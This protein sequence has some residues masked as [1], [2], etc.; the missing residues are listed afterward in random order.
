MTSIRK[1]FI[2]VFSFLLVISLPLFSAGDKTMPDKSL[3]KT[4]GHEHRRSGIHDGN[5][6]LT[7]FFNYG[8]FG[9]WF[10]DSN[11][12]QSGIWPKGSGHSYFAEFCPFVGAEVYDGY[13]QR[14]HIFSDG[15]GHTGRAD[16][17]PGGE[18]QYCFEP[19]PGY[20]DPNQDYIAMVNAKGSEDNDG[21]DGIPAHMGSEDDDGKP[22]SW[23][24]VWP[25]KPDW[26]DPRTGVPF[27]NGQYG[28][29]ARASQESYFRMNDDANDEFYFFP[30]PADSSKRG[31]GLEV[32]VRG[33]QWA[34]PQ[35]ED[36]LIFT[37]WITNTGEYLYEKTIFG[38]YGD[39][40]IGEQEDNSDDLS[41]FNKDED[42][43]YQWD[44][45]LYSPA[46]GGFSPGYF[47]WK[48]LESPG[49]PHDGIDNDGDGL[50][51]AD[52]NPWDESQEDG[53]DNDGD[54][55]PKID[56]IGSDGLGPDYPDYPGPDPDGTEG[57][58]VPDRGEPNFEYTDND[59][60]DQ[61]GL[62]SF[63]S[64]DWKVTLIEL[65][66]DEKLW[67]QTIPGSFSKALS[68][69][70]IVMHYGSGY[71][72]V[73]PE[74]NP[75]SRRKFAISMVMGADRDDLV[76][77][78][79]TMQQIYNADYNFAAVPLKP[80]VTA[81]PGDQRVTL[82]WDKISEGSRDPIYGYDFEGYVIYRATDPGFLE[83]YIGTDTYGNKSFNK[84]IAQFDLKNGLK[85]PHPVARDG[86]Q[87]NM[88]SDTGLQYTFIDSGQTW[89]GP[90]ENG[91]TYYYA[92]CSYDKG[93][94]DDFF[95]RGLTE[96]DSLQEKAPAV[97]EKRIQF[98]ASGAV[99]FIDVNCAEVV[100]N[101]PVVGYIDPPELNRDNGWVRRVEGHGTG[102]IIIDAL[103]PIK[104][105]NSAQ[106]EITFDD[107]SNYI[108]ENGNT[109]VIDTTLFV[110][111][112]K[113]N[114][115]TV[116]IDTNFVLLN[117][118]HLVPSS[119]VVTVQGEDTEY[120][121]GVDYEVG[122]DV[123]NFRALPGGALPISDEEN[124]YYAEV[125][126]QYYPVYNSTYINGEDRNE[127]FDGL[128]ILVNN[129]ELEAST[130]R[131]GWLTGDDHQQYLAQFGFI[132]ENDLIPDEYVTDT[133]YDYF[134]GLY[135]NNGYAVPYD[136]MIAIY[137]SVVTQDFQKRP[138]NFLVFNLTTGDT[139]D[140]VF[141]DQDRDSML[142]DQDLLTPLTYVKN[143]PRGTWQVRFSAPR[144]QVVWR[145]SLNEFGYSVR[146][147]EGEI[148]KLPVDTIM[149]EKIPPKAGDIFY[150]AVNKPFSGADR[151]SFEAQAP[152][153]DQKI[154]QDESQLKNIAVVPNPYVVTASWEPQHFY[155][156]GRGTRK[157]DFIH[158]PQKCTI[159]IFTMRGYLVDTIYH[160]SPINDGAE[161]WDML[162]KDGME[163]AYGVYIFHVST[164]S[165]QNYIGKF[166]VIK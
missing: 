55:D 108:V 140:F 20:F 29:Y 134:V 164:P 41:Q 106:Y 152:Y 22:D 136:Y 45:D 95:E 139:S 112:L 88:G 158:L 82:Y 104:I 133:N 162:S 132:G 44:K 143:R 28:A 46:D 19:L 165:G 34:D 101:V 97:C 119:T 127:Y 37:Y 166:A 105:I 75:D 16:M 58:G 67:S 54:W 32:E 146:D 2:L 77:N 17:A 98:D 85:G 118:E 125:S 50:P 70:D 151:F 47:G 43:V 30:D 84:P 86:I 59:E 73:P 99:T 102:E 62:T 64:A 60:S 69:V 10:E 79:Q 12:L 39:A 66:E 149:V 124:T 128:R 103:D 71:F 147:K 161:S 9:N 5:N 11:R 56:D 131:S 48:F 111:D 57:N 7:I 89:Q 63:L 116:K 36:I 121:I 126:Y 150:L 153:V 4:L 148:I 25:D 24:T 163:I 76:R 142:S 94:Y 21:P 13:G 156:S 1:I 135:T 107:S 91:Q 155:S 122:F 51:G 35:A 65:G 87:F 160:D 137:D 129:H 114:T 8:N 15:L 78:A 31:L 96:L 3:K 138:A 154:A 26:V 123:G 92:V 159:K 6:I 81:V 145:D 117:R 83:S 144:D 90:V 157:I 49:N 80:N 27:W 113:V 38:M 23:P 52:G 40:D 14:R 33:Y 74:P 68:Q 53:I 141:F 120:E 42:I 109:I 61:I 100:P 18:Y 110:K 115:E 93:Y 130:D 72:E